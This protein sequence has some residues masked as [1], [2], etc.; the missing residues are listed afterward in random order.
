MII[1]V[2][3]DQVSWAMKHATK[4]HF[5]L[6]LGREV[7]LSDCLDSIEQENILI[8]V[9]SKATEPVHRRLGL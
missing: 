4:L 9:C 2:K 3:K 6:Q 5:N 7:S 8:F 1:L